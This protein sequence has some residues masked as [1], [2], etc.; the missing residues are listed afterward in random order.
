[1]LTRQT[2]YI[3]RNVVKTY[4]SQLEYTTTPTTICN[5]KNPSFIVTTTNKIDE[6]AVKKLKLYRACC[7]KNPSYIVTTTYESDEHADE[8]ARNKNQQSRPY[9][10]IP[11]I[12]H[13]IWQFCPSVMS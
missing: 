13:S 10:S 1:M 11:K 9:S 6:H 8:H 4:C 5:A 2:K 12:C 3:N 7:A